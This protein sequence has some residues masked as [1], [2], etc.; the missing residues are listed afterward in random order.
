MNISPGVSDR[1]KL[2]SSTLPGGLNSI[3]TVM[4]FQEYCEFVFYGTIRPITAVCEVGN[5]LRLIRE[6]SVDTFFKVYATYFR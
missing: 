6:G 5:L 4:Y 1:D 2:Y 3:I